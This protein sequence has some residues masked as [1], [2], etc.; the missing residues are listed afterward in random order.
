M[1]HI[2]RYDPG[3]KLTIFLCLAMLLCISP[4]PAAA[5]DGDGGQKL[6]EIAT[7]GHI[8]LHY[9]GE[10]RQAGAEIQDNTLIEKGTQL[11][12]Y[13]TYDI[14][15]DKIGI[16]QADTK[17]YL[18]VSPHLVLSHLENGSSLTIET[19]SGRDHHGHPL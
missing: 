8:G 15:A 3:S 14:P 16:V 1:G 19:G 9:A 18:E 17:Y 5:A 2:H 10:N 4:M 6:S 12:L 13:Y 7:F 11:M